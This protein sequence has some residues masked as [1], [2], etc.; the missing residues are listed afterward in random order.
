MLDT[1]K[2]YQ[3]EIAD[4]KAQLEIQTNLYAVLVVN[5]DLISTQLFMYQEQL[6]QAQNENVEGVT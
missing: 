6:M 5:S 2:G 3:D 4:L 1:L